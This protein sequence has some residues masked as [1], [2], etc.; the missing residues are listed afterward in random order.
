MNYTS[1]DDGRSNL[2][3]DNFPSI[4]T[5]IHASKQSGFKRKSAAYFFI[6]GPAN[7][8]MCMNVNKS[9]Q[10][11]ANALLCLSIGDCPSGTSVA[12]W[13]RMPPV[14]DWATVGNVTVILVGSLHIQ[15]GMILD[16]RSCN[17]SAQAPA[18]FITGPCFSAGCLWITMIHSNM[19]AGVWS[20]IAVTISVSKQLLLY[21]NG[22]V[23]RTIKR[24]LFEF[25]RKKLLQIEL[26]SPSWL[27]CH[28]E[29]PGNQYWNAHVGS[30]ED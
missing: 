2:P 8:A 7:S 10:F 4:Q 23:T 14:I 17:R 18:L 3:G 9:S 20:H 5:A 29:P 22:V 30:H 6:P 27:I 25:L 28:G 1:F 13:V 26:F 21:H 15:L 16:L 11:S 24:Y 19:L 12:L